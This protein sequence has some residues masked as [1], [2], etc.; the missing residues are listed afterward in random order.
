[1]LD[2]F[3]KVLGKVLGGN[4]SDLVEKTF[5]PQAANDRSPIVLAGALIVLSALAAY[6]GSFR[7]PFLFDDSG[8][9][10]ENPTI[11]HLTALGEVL[12]PPNNGSGVTGRPIINL[13]L[14]IDYALG[15]MTVGGY[16]ATN[17]QVHIL[18]GLVLFGL[19]RRTLLGPVLRG[20]LREPLVLA[21]VIAL[22]W[23]LHPLQT[24]SVVCIAQ[25]TEL[26]G[27]LFYLLTL[28][29]FARGVE[30]G[31]AGIWKGLAV[32]ACALGMGSKEVMAT[33][34]LM[35]LL[36]DRTFVAGSFR[37]A[38]RRRAG[39]HCAL[40]ATWL[41]LGYLVLR[42]GGSR[43]SSAGFGLGV[44]WWSYAL[45]QCDAIVRYLGLSIWPHPLVLDYGNPV[46]TDP[47]R[48]WAQAL[49]L[50]LLVGATIV[51]LVR[52]PVAGF[53][54]AW[55]FGILAPSSSVIPL[56]TQTIAEH[57]MY[58]PL[59]AIVTA[60]VAGADAIA[61]RRGLI[62][63]LAA[64]V[65]LGVLTARRV[66]DYRSELSIWTDTLAKCPDNPRVHVNLG[67]AL[68]DAGRAGD[69]IAQYTAA[70]QLDPRRAEACSGM[71]A[72]LLDLGRP[73]EAIPFCE[74][75]LTLRTDFADAQCNL[76]TALIQTGRT[77]E[78]ISHFE[79]AL[80]LRPDFAEAQSNLAGALIKA[81]RLPEAM[82][83]GQAAL[84]LDPNLAKAHDNLGIALFLSGRTGEAQA[85]FEAA[86]RLD[87]AFADAHYNLATALAK[88][89]RIGEAI[90]QCEEALRIN[91]GFAAARRGLES[92]QAHQGSE[93]PSQ[94]Q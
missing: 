5:S 85:Q 93:P 54:G 9:I 46:V 92:L 36:Y 88:E 91:P 77:E 41:V 80:R 17:L 79:A 50:A 12:S 73:A 70:L 58:L 19:V 67:N 15:G 34:P 64:A 18:A 72:A 13:S 68:K 60:A 87:P 51:A 78:A 23:T 42:S 52:R 86:L 22:A 59:V 75:A 56:V 62:A 63:C 47:T 61:G 44:A 94:N 83:H 10:A 65:G 66:E 8:V 45:E 4:G 90:R 20:R 21:F 38:W 14:A 27:G 24:E 1:M 29:A 39:W 49:L 48:V 31:S 76:A 25:R 6:H 81:G 43:G 33:A 37:E 69:A 74:T 35:V 11:R 53:L 84:R 32:A 57:R 16:H 3:K 71:A 55:F 2:Q 26:I 89:G 40:A 30:P 82:D 28:Y 7:V